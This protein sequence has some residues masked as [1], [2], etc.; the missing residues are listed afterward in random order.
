MHQS[1]A[2]FHFLFEFTSEWIESPQPIPTLNLQAK[3]F[4]DKKELYNMRK[5]FQHKKYR[6]NRESCPTQV[7]C[8]VCPA[9][10][11]LKIV[12]AGPLPLPRAL[13]PYMYFLG[14]YTGGHI[15]A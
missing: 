8:P 11:R 3:R 9:T 10:F 13:G 7:S 14:K 4:K 15:P 2:P 12:I 5:P 1:K 6:K